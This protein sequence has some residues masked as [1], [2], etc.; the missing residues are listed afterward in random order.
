M[1]QSFR[2]FFRSK[3]GIVVTL[4]FLALIAIAF[5]SSDVA[6][7][8]TF[9]G[10]AGGDRVAVVGNEKVSSSDLSRATTSALESARQQNPTLTMEA[11]LAQ[12]ALDEVLDQMLQRFAIAEYGKQVGLR[13][14]T[15]LVNSELLQIDAFRGADGNFNQETYR[16]ALAQRGLS[17]ALVRQDM[18]ASLL[19]NQVLA[20]VSLGTR[21]P[22]KLATQYAKLLRETR[23]GA[24]AT[25][26]SSAFAP[27]GDPTTAQLQAYYTSNRSSYLRPER[28]VIRYATFGE[29]AL[30]RL[31]APTDAQIRER[32]ERDRQQYAA[33]ETRRLS[34]VIVP[35]QAAADALVAE[36][37]GGK[38]LAA[39][40]REKGLE[41]GPMGPISQSDY[42]AQSSAAVAQAAFAA[43]S[44]EIAR[45]ARAPL[46]WYVVRVEEI[47]R[48]P[49][50]T[51]DQA[52]AE[53]ADTLATEQRR[54]ALLDLGAEI[55]QE[56]DAGGN[57]AE[58]AQELGLELQTTAPLTADGR[59]YGSADSAPAILATALST[60]FAMDEE[61]PQ[62]AEIVPGETFLVFDVAEITESAAAPLAEIRDRV[63]ADWKKSQGATAAKAAAD[64]V[65]AR[66]REGQTLAAALAAEDATI[67]APDQIN[68][69]RQQL[70]QMGGQV[71]PVLALLFSMAEK[72]TKRLEAPSEN[73]WFVVQLDEIEPG[74]VEGDNQIILATQRE[75]SQLAGDEYIRQ[76]VTAIQEQVGVERNETAIEA[77]RR[78]LSGAGSAN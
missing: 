72:T 5:A 28:R 33:S 27:Q 23:R 16:A 20:P 21:M 26:P 50:R 25:L 61:Q 69:G 13:A 4:A 65:M 71:P 30:E 1:L 38:T 70:A 76:F 74:N 78:Q 51:L 63:I 3:I 54:E 46:G 48:Q 77:V 73:G 35:T 10:I 12:G 66:I 45:P 52:R 47:D 19:S 57:L 68:M 75:L 40:A 7:T 18:A 32:Y 60:A 2:S 59:V 56:L 17:D 24:I 36:V 15:N 44:G 53:I 49:G 9:G 22:A 6:N 29:E 43:N 67:P 34:Q 42:A 37:R 11:F 8:G 14:G 58:V 41:A 64:R 55:E 31:S 62:L 39:A